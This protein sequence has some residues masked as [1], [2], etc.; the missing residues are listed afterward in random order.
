MPS[1]QGEPGSKR[2]RLDVEA[3]DGTVDELLGRMEGI[4]ERLRHKGV[5]VAVLGGRKVVRLEARGAEEDPNPPTDIREGILDV[6]QVDCLL[7]VPSAEQD[8]CPR[9][10]YA[11][12]GT[13]Y[14]LM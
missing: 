6:S 10:I 11:S 7:V 9:Y 1:E 4:M 5:Q 2:V 13:V 12:T 14:H 3:E 8:G